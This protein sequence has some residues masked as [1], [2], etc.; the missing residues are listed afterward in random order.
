MADVQLWPT[1]TT[2]GLQTFAGGRLRF[3]PGDPSRGSRLEFEF[4]RTQHDVVIHQVLPPVR[5]YGPP[6]KPPVAHVSEP[7]LYQIVQANNRYLR[8]Q[9]PEVDLPKSLLLEYILED[10][11]LP[12]KDQP[13]LSSML[14]GLSIDKQ[15]DLIVSVGGPL[16]NELYCMFIENGQF[17][18][19]KL[20]TSAKSAAT[21]RTPVQ[22]LCSGPSLNQDG[23][24]VF[25]ARTHD[26]TTLFTYSSSNN[27]CITDHRFDM[28][29]QLKTSDTDHER[30]VDCCVGHTI[31]DTLHQFILLNSKAELWKVSGIGG[32]SSVR[33]VGQIK[34]SEPHNITW[35][36][37]GI[38]P[39]NDCLVVGLRDS[40][41]M[42]DP[43]VSS[44]N[45]L[46]SSS[47]I[48]LLEQVRWLWQFL[49]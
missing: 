7:K 47:A 23:N 4:A 33:Q 24:A 1:G 32:K 21:L 30:H 22:Q 43:R 13:L 10:Q 29:Y 3:L 42:V 38:Y 15:H 17:D 41:G 36:R 8:T 19:P 35:A 12:E 14:A 28:G 25:L 2:I 20:R 49:I 27:G 45:H 37:C 39:S 16:G 11:E 40:V 31:N 46:K 34:H 9:H 6:I 48:L 5:F 44:L 26:A 18:V